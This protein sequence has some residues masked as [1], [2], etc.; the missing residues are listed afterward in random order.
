ME[1]NEEVW[2][3]TDDD[4]NERSVTLYRVGEDGTARVDHGPQ[5]V[6]EGDLLEYS[7]SDTV[8]YYRVD[9]NGLRDGGLSPDD[10]T[11]TTDDSSSAVSDD[12]DDGI[13]Y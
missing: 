1:F 5:N 7:G 2:K 9:E 11:V 10:Q 3:G 13:K 6:Q 12:D 4:G 8:G